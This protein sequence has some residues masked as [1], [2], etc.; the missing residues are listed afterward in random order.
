MKQSWK[1]LFLLT[2]PLTTCCTLGS[3]TSARAQITPD[4]S[5][6][7]ESSSIGPDNIQGISFDRIRGGATRGANLFHSFQEFNVGNGQ[8]VYF[9]N[10]AG[11]GNI[12][13]RVTGVNRSNILGRL[14]VLGNANLFLINPNGIF[15]GPNSSLDV[16]GSFLGSTANSLIFDNGFEFSATNPIAPPLLT[17]NIPIGLRFR[18]N[19]GNITNQSVVRD[20]TRSTVGL[21]V[22]PGNSLALVGGNV[23]LEQGGRLTAAGGRIEL[24]GL[25]GAGTVGLETTGNTF[26]LN[27]PANS[28]LSNVTLANDAL[29]A[30]LGNGEGDI[31]VNANIFTATNGGRLVGGTRGG[32]NGGNITV[33]SNEFNISGVGPQTGFGAGIYQQVIGNDSSN[34]GNITVNTKS[35]NASSG[36]QLQNSVLSG[37]VGNAGN[38]ELNTDNLILS[39]A[40]INS[41]TFGRGN[42]G[43]VTL[44]AENGDISLAGGSFIFSTVESGGMGNA[45]KIDVIT[46]NL[47]LTGGSQLQTLVRAGEQ[48]NAGNITVQASGTVR[49]AGRDSSQEN[50]N[51]SGI[52]STLGSGASG[53]AG[54]ITINAGSIFTDDASL[55]TTNAGTGIA[56]D[57]TLNARDQISIAESRISAQGNQGGIFI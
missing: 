34:A 28:S 17:V 14:G 15:F 47:S 12:L 44:R 23:S 49:I 42:A 35:F 33:N 36:G 54:N 20:N 8:L 45:G 10:P 16:R 56:G 21:R 32:G 27:F 13:T 52:F 22:N 53:N 1:T 55:R 51:P 40:Q 29:A 3:I 41:S 24:G 18:D 9:S 5:L 25:A 7:A 46:R 6:G 4:N 11:I 39:N 57:I 37:A 31:A 38:I 19:P 50:P 2:L 30:V 26:K 48:S 43:N